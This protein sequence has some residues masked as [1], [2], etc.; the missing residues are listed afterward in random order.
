MLPHILNSTEELQCRDVGQPRS[1]SKWILLLPGFLQ[2]K[3]IVCKHPIVT[4]KSWICLLF[5][6]ISTWLISTVITKQ[7]ISAT[8]VVNGQWCQNKQGPT[9][10]W[11][12][13]EMA[14]GG[15]VFARQALNFISY[16]ANR[17][18]NA[19]YRAFPCVVTSL[20][21]QPRNTEFT[22]Y[23]AETG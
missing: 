9:R 11:F 16:Y 20:C 8:E 23:L 19:C 6:G 17:A 1:V 13:L 14:G 21:F 2:R 4:T 10:S 18:R 12:D 5:C 22:S 7:L 15:G 3:E